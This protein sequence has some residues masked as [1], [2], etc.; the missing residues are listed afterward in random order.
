[1]LAAKEVKDTTLWIYVIE[2]MHYDENWNVLIRQTNETEQWKK[3]LRITGINYI[4]CKIYDSS[5]N[6]RIY[7]SDILQKWVNIFLKLTLMVLIFAV[8]AQNREN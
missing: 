7:E 6:S 1:M 5:F 8:F 4:K 3:D 2:N